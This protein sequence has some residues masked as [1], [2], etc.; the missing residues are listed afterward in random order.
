[1]V[2]PLFLW[3][4]NSLALFQ[5]LFDLFRLWECWVAQVPVY[6]LG[7]P[8]FKCISIWKLNPFLSFELS[9]S[10]KS[11][12]YPRA[13]SECPQ[14]SS[15]CQGRSETCVTISGGNPS[16]LS[17]LLTHWSTLSI[18][19]AFLGTTVPER[20]IGS[21]PL[22]HI[23]PSIYWFWHTVNLLLADKSSWIL[24]S[25]V[26]FAGLGGVCPPHPSASEEDL[27]DK[28]C[29]VTAWKNFI[30]GSL[31]TECPGWTLPSLG[32]LCSWCYRAGKSCLFNTLA[33]GSS[34]WFLE[35]TGLAGEPAWPPCSAHKWKEFCASE[36]GLSA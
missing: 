28:L 34:G 24:Q 6:V 4:A 22:N 31:F 30:L 11:L 26:D 13:K 9:S 35:Q 5:A 29:A 12:L 18:L 15:G 3:L 33:W 36:M 25:V 21:S 8:L 32:S 14:R 17:N 2:P 23:Y 27:H 7:V 19:I 10:L 1:M 20:L 16:T